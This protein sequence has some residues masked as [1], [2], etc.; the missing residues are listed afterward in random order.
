MKTLKI[1]LL[2]VAAATMFLACGSDDDKGAATITAVAEYTVPENLDLLSISVNV[3]AP[4]DAKLEKITYQVISED[5]GSE[6]TKT[7]REVTSFVDNTNY[8]GAIVNIGTSTDYL[9][10][11]GYTSSMTKIKI[12]A[13]VKDGDETS[14][15]ITLKATTTP[16]PPEETELG[17]YTSAGIVL[18]TG[19][20][21]PVEYNGV[22]YSTDENSIMGIKYVTNPS[23]PAGGVFAKIETISKASTLVEVSNDSYATVEE[24]ETAYNA[25][26]NKVSIMNFTSDDMKAY[27]VKY[28]ISKVNDD[29]VLIKYVKHVKAGD[30]KNLLLFD[31]KK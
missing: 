21:Q 13:K 26:E 25:A 23:N 19:G 12:T 24:L 18:L 5:N 22:T 30:G 14:K 28:F 20:G 2:F 6:V 4:D 11:L 3:T 31:Y 7:L 17:E 29:Y 10:V 9:V 16:E 15:V 27:A 8:T 1:L